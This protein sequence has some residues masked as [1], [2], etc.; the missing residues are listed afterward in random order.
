MRIRSEASRQRGRVPAINPWIGYPTPALDLDFAEMGA[1]GIFDS[2]ITF[3]RASIGTYFG[4]NGVMQTA[5]DNVPRLAYDP[6]TGAPLGLLVEESRTNQISYSEDF[7][8]PIWARSA[9]ADV[10]S[11]AIIAPDGA[12]TADILEANS[13][14]IPYISQSIAITAGVTYC[15]SFFAKK[16]D[17]SRVSILLYGTNFNSGGSNVGGTFDLDTGTIYSQSAANAGIQNAGGGWFRVW[18]AQTATGTNAA[19]QWQLSRFADAGTTTAGYGS[20]IW[21]AQVEI[22]AF[23][24][25]YIP[26]DSVSVTRAA[27]SASMS[28]TNFSDWYNQSEGAF[29][30]EFQ[31]FATLADSIARVIFAAGDSTTFNESIYSSRISN[32]G[33]IGSSIID[34]GVSQMSLTQG[35]HAS[36]PGIKYKIALATKLND[37]SAALD[38]T[39]LTDTIMTLPAV[40]FLGIGRASWAAGNFLCGYIKRLT[41]WNA[42]LPDN[43]LAS[44][45]GY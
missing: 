20:Y 15:F 29:L 18:I 9:G 5:A 8:K 43:L 33:S 32:S 41:Y 40:N 24:S 1:D 6:V 13:T 17:V 35:V 23:P 38:G 19:E 4:A 37:G 39:V 2:R 11:N 26:A 21:G 7:S 34:N 31:T 10:V 30:S 16:K 12:L 28:G 22:G 27:D 45:T 25:S 3:S 42:R 14:V 36:D 44:L